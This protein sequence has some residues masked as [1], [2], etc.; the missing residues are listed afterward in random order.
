MTKLD[1]L[2]KNKIACEETGITIKKTCC[3][4]C[5]HYS[6]CA[7]DAYIKDGKIIKIEG[8]SDN[9]HTKGTLCPRGAA[10]R[11]YIYSDERILHPLKRIGEKGEGKFEKITWEEAYQT[12]AEKFNGYKERHGAHSVAFMV[13]FEKWY[14]PPLLKLANAFGSPNYITEGSTCQEAHKMAWELVFGD[15][16]PADYQHTELLIVWSRN[17]VYSNLDNNRG[18]YEAIERG[19]KMI[20]VDPRITPI[21][22]KAYMHLQL[23]PGTDGALA[24]GMA[25]IIVEEELY[26][27]DF[28]EKYVHGFSEFKEMVKDYPLDKVS[29]ITGVPEAMIEETARLYARTK[30]AAILTS[31][32]PVVHHVNGIQNYRAVISLV[33]LTGNFDIHG[34]NRVMSWSYLHVS[35]FTPCNEHEYVGKK[36]D[37]MPAIGFKEFPVW[38]ALNPE[39]GQAMMLP[40]YILE[41]KPYEIK[42]MYAAGMSHMM[43]PDTKYL[44]KSLKELEFLVSTDLF[45][46]EVCKYA[47]IVLPACSSFERCDVKIFPENTIQCL[48]PAIEPLGESK[49]DIEIIFDI[50]RHLGIKDEKL[51]MTNDEYMNYIIEPTGR[52]IEEIRS[53]GGLMETKYLSGSYEEKKYLKSGFNTPS[54][55][56]ELL[57]TLIEKYAD[58]Y[59][60]DVLPIYKPFSEIRKGYEDSHYPLIM[61]SGSRKPQYMHSRTFRM[62]WIRELEPIDLLDISREDAAEL[63]LKNNDKVIISTPKGSIEATIRV[64]MA[65]QKG[66][67]HMYHGNVNA[68]VNQL[69]DHN[70]LDPISGYP[71]FKNFPCR[72]DKKNVEAT[73]GK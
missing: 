65:V 46:T 61:N 11:Q 30:P 53:N 39:Q 21:S 17:P 26:D 1:S 70:Y 63:D 59:G 3:D 32:S 25:K 72:I 10:N 52:T 37:D 34:G 71:G 4:I 55:K 23:K 35:S 45:M 58:E 42:A 68:D 20:V 18:F 13:G 16:G 41:G 14:R 24:L 8:S 54:G 73:G 2:I 6:H 43:W 56:V 49:N 50:A 7:I 33:A 48:D 62:R 19:L 47:D 15:L 57:S 36:C 31:A 5:N 51:N 67:V 38:A 60:Y 44:L 27:K 64:N 66:V 9:P 12:I 22:Q 69:M 28:V 29:K 40:Q